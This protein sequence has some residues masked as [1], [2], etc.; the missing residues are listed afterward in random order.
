MAAETVVRA[1][2][3]ANPAAAE[4]YLRSVGARFRKTDEAG[5]PLYKSQAGVVF[6]VNAVPSLRV[7]VLANCAC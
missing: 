4:Q 2:P 3:V 1:V 5:R 7:E 6:R